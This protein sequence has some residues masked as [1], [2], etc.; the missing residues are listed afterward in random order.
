[1]LVVV[2]GKGP[3]TVEELVSKTDTPFT[4]AVM[5]V[6]LPH[7]FKM[8]VL[9]SFDGTRDPLDHL[10]TYKALMDLQVVPDQII[11]KAFPTTLKGPARIWFHRLSSGTISRFVDLSRLF[12]GH[13][14]G[15]QRQRRPSTSLFN[16]KQ[17]ENE[18]LRES[19]A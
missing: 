5:K 4:P 6:P 13:Y 2:K 1:M 10:E 19:R 18:T 12:V 8:P 3:R 7:K 16:I 9:E 14:I 17:R 15:G 11:C